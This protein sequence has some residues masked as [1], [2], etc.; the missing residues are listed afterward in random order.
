VEIP[1]DR[2]FREWIDSWAE[3]G[4]GVPCREAQAD[5]VPCLELGRECAECEEAFESWL[6]FR[7]RRGVVEELPD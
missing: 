6:A 1:R 2:L 3:T 7:E 5:G 4:L